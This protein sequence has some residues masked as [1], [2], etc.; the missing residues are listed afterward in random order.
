[1]NEFVF[2]EFMFT[3]DERTQGVNE[4]KALGSDFALITS[5]FNIDTID[6]RGYGSTFQCISGKIDAGCATVIKLSNKFL[7]DRM[8]ISYIPDELKNKYRR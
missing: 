7:S 1:M 8:R 5:D 4:I 2:V 3:T 6:A